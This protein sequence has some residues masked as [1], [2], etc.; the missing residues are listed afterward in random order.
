MLVQKF[1]K[2]TVPMLAAGALLT[3][4]TP[5]VAS[6]GIIEVPAEV[7]TLTAAEELA[8]PGDI[9]L[10]APGTY[11]EQLEITTPDI[12]VR[13]EDR[14]TTIID[15]GGIRPYGIVAMADGVRVENLTV[16]DAT[17]YGLLFTGLHDESGPQA[18]TASNYE[19]WD[20]EQFPPLQ[21]FLADHI[22]ATNNGLYG[23]YAFNSQHGAII[24]SYASG[25]AD[26]G[27][28]VGQCNE[29]DILVADNIAERN[30]VGFEN[31][32]A[33]DSVVVTGNRLTNNRVGLTL[34]S[35]YQEAFVPQTGNTIIGN[36]IADN[37][38]EASPAQ[39]QGGFATGIGISGGIQNLITHNLITGHPRSGVLIENTEDLPAA[40]NAF[41]ANVFSNNQVDFTNTSAQ[42]TPAYGNCVDDTGSITALP[43][44]LLEELSTITCDYAP[45]TLPPAST[46]GAQQASADSTAGPEAPAGLSYRQVALP[47][48]QPNLPQRET[49]PL[50]PDTVEM[51]DLTSI[52][53][54][55]A[56][57]FT[58]LAGVR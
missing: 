42:R 37:V 14:N 25:S 36:L 3:S 47:K 54:P 33:N 49:Y 7:D 53:V 43:T 4:C 55:E 13:G 35:N 58:D 39:A 8:E 28:Y 16:T 11:E 57:L 10:I 21:R 45:D 46:D 18:P 51:P 40:D 44:G 15:G 50:L 23:I 2:I 48:D 30:A 24:N 20:S 19:P 34:L 1:L 29:C 5:D 38:E 26:S 9:I 56:D 31:S 17:F 27:L 32:N 52:Q 22:T 12:T 6:D 41:V